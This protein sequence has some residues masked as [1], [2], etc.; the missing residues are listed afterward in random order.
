[1]APTAETLR[2]SL[3]ELTLRDAH[4]LRRRVDRLRR[5]ADPR[6]RERVES[7]IAAARERLER[8]RAAVPPVS[9]PPELP[10]SARRDDLRAA[11]ADHQVVVLAE[12]R[13]LF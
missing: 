12:G 8:R 7:E 10:V 4:R 11:I 5:T 2:T 9:Y 13:T 1:M 3:D 6:A